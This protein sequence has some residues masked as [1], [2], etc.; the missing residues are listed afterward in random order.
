M[1]KLNVTIDIDQALQKLARLPDEVREKALVRALNKT[2]DQVKVQASREIRAAGYGLP[3]AKIKKAIAIDR[4][5][6]STLVATVR[7]TGRPIGLINYGA[8]QTKAGVSV[9]VKNGRRIINGA[10][11]ATMP[12]GHKGVFYRKGA[13]H[14]KVGTGRSAW[15]GLPIDEL[16]GPAIPSAFM[17]QVVQDALVAAVHDK[18]PDIFRRELTFL[19]LK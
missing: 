8:R 13:K 15:H 1:I 6:A 18:F 19:S 3:A 16:F 2:A 4:A 12:S 14:K 9:Q 17:N 11:I 7:A 5:G 10:F